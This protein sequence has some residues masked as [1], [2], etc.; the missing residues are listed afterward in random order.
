MTFLSTAPVGYSDSGI[1]VRMATFG[2]GLFTVTFEIYIAS[3]D[4]QSLAPN[5]MYYMG[6]TPM[7]PLIQPYK[8]DGV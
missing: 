1:V 3:L 4:I 7:S 2:P 5:G 8:A 6:R